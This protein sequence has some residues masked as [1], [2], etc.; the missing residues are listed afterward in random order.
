VLRMLHAFM[1][2]HDSLRWIDS[3]TIAEQFGRRK[4]LPHTVHGVTVVCRR[5]A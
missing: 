3:G 4:G 5:L 1:C 2:A